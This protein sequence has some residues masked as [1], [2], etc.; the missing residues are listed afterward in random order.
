MVQ[1]KSFLGR[2]DLE[3]GERYGIRR[4]FSKSPGVFVHDP[5]EFSRHRSGL[6]EIE[7]ALAPTSQLWEAEILNILGHVPYVR[8]L[9]AL[10]LVQEVSQRNRGASARLN[11]FPSMKTEV[12]DVGVNF[13]LG[14]RARVKRSFNACLLE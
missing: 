10:D 6:I 3:L 5:T 7:F 12:T 9:P 13:K 4:E 14:S 2:V 8:E 11:L 1:C